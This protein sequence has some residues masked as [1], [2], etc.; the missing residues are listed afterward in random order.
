MLENNCKVESFHE[1][2]YDLREKL[3][4][5]QVSREKLASVDFE[6]NTLICKQVLI[7]V[8]ALLSA[9]MAFSQVVQTIKKKAY[10]RLTVLS[11]ATAA[12]SAGI[13]IT[14]VCYDIVHVCYQIDLQKMDSHRDHT[15]V[16]FPYCLGMLLGSALFHFFSLSGISSQLHRPKLRIKEKPVYKSTEDTTPYEPPVTRLNEVCKPTFDKGITINDKGND[17]PVF[18]EKL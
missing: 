3:I 5:A 17:N 14:V 2:H 15:Y 11:A 13:V 4:D 18:S 16:G 8:A 9:V 6:Y 7:L 1:L 10:P 12:I